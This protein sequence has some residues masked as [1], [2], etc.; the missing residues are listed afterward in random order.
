MAAAWA[1]GGAHYR[2]TQ[3]Q[4]RLSSSPG[5]YSVVAAIA[6]ASRRG[7]LGQETLPVVGGRRYELRRHLSARCL[8]LLT[9]P[10]VF[11]TMISDNV[12]S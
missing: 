1:S 11:A 7:R 9:V 8:G 12:P 2:A 10:A 6:L 4:R 3:P 5:D